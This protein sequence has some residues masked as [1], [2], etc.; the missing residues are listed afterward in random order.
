MKNDNLDPKENAP[1]ATPVTP[2]ELRQIHQHRVE[3]QHDR[4][5]RRYANKET[6]VK[7]AA[8]FKKLEG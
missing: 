5:R 2:D 3:R 6:L 8:A 1:Q 4:N 7:L